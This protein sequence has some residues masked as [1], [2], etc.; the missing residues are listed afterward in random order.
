[1]SEKEKEVQSLGQVQQSLGRT[2][3]TDCNLG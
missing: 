1:M 2:K 3:T